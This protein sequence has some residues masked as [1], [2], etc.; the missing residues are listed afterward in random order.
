MIYTTCIFLIEPELR[1]LGNHF[2]DDYNKS[3][4]KNK[5]LSIY[6]A[7]GLELSGKEEWSRVLLSGLT[8]KGTICAYDLEV[9]FSYHSTSFWAEIVLKLLELIDYIDAKTDMYIRFD[10]CEFSQIGKEAV[11]RKSGSFKSE[12][13]QERLYDC[14]SQKYSDFH[15]KIS[16]IKNGATKTDRKIHNLIDKYSNEDLINLGEYI[17]YK[18]SKE[19]TGER[20]QLCNLFIV[21][22]R[23][24]KERPEINLSPNFSSENQLL[25]EC[26]GM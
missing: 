17:R 9:S 24:M 4:N 22:Y 10:G 11:R 18:I 15:E 7:E 12:L 5:L 19:D 23:E 8:E 21:I 20:A 2:K 6:E 25:T 13:I 14:I 3:I 26:L 16:T 1:N